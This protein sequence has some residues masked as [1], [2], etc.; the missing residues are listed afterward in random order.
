M[1]YEKKALYYGVVINLFSA[2]LGLTFFILTRSQALFL[3]AFISLI[4]SISTIVSIVISNVINK[5]DSEKFPLGRYAIE[6]IFLVFRAIL[7]L[8][9]ILYTLFEGISTIYMFYQGTLVSDL[10]ID[11]IYMIVYCILMTLSCLSITVV[12]TYFNKKLPV[13]SEII[14]LE[15]TSSLYDGL[16][17]IFATSSL[18]I[19]TY[20]DFFNKIEPIGDSIVVIILSLFYLSI[21]IKEII[22]QI[23][24][25]SD[26]R[27]NQDIEKEVKTYL[28]EFFPVY[29][30]YDIYCSY[31]GDVCSIYICLYPESKKDV[32]SLNIDFEK[33]RKKL[34]E[35]YQNAKVILILAKNKLHNL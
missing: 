27:T 1:H 21:P 12:Y 16:V 25:L 32:E 11:L 9:I 31:S 28:Q 34:Y 15:I 35:E 33:I 19:F 8:L 30:I 18:L 26:N 7:M 17:T 14:R 29:K 5:K 24:I 10:N 20:V 22:K 2:I 6:N 3:D 13:K 23:K 4:L